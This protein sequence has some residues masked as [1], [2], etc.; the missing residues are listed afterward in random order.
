MTYN[1]SSGMLNRTA[2]TPLMPLLSRCMIS[3]RLARV[4][5]EH[6]T[7]H[8]QHCTLMTVYYLRSWLTATI[9]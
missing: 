2:P 3:L 6:T 8:R 7:S 4:C 1:V 9:M 5:R